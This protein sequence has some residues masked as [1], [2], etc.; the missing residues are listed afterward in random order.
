MSRPW[1]CR[2]RW[3]LSLGLL[4]GGAACTRD[5]PEQAAAQS[6]QAAPTIVL[7]RLRVRDATPASSRPVQ[8]PAEHL[9][10][11]ARR[12]L[13]AAGVI[14]DREPQA[15]DWRLEAHLT[16]SYG[17]TKGEGLLAQPEAATARFIWGADLSFREPQ[18]PEASHTWLESSED[19]PWAEGEVGLAPTLADLAQ[20]AFA[21]IQRGGATHI[22]MLRLAP[23]ALIERLSDAD[24]QVRLAAIERL[25]RL[26]AAETYPAI[27]QRLGSE[28]DALVRLRLIGAAGELADASFAEPLIMLAELR[29]RE[30]L[31]A[32]VNAL[33]QIDTPRVEDFLDIL[34][35]HDAADVRELVQQAQR[36]RARA[37]RGPNPPD[38]PATDAAAPP[39]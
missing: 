2:W 20:S 11:V 10:G 22:Q 16:A 24:A 3:A 32:V 15:G 6:A 1:A 4:M 13:A 30:L 36:Q 19:R 38:A 5:A 35:L 14:T 17:L 28:T 27:A 26:Q 23:Q 39:P 7:T 12:G 33:T 37:R 18:D 29:D 21:P 31:R 9:E 8:L 25:A 34:S